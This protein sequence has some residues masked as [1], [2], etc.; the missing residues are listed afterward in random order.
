MIFKYIQNMSKNVIITL[1][2]AMKKIFNIVFVTMLFLLSLVPP[3]FASEVRY[4]YVSSTVGNGIS[5]RKGPGTSYDKLSDGLGE[6]EQVKILSEHKPDDNTTSDC[7]LWYKI[8]FNEVADGIGYA[9]AD[10]IKIIEIQTDEEFEESLEAFPESY[11][12][13]LRLLH[14][15]YPNAIFKAYDTRLDFNTVVKNE[16][17]LGKSLIWDSNSSR[18]GLKNMDSYDYVTNTF[19]NNYP[20]GGENWYAASEATIAYYVD[21]RNFLTESRVFMFEIL[22]Y[23]S[24]THT[25]GGV[26]AILAGSFMAREKVDGGDKSFAQVIMEAGKTYNISPYYL[27]S[28]ILQET[29]Y[30]RSSLVKGDY[31]GVYDQFDGYYNFFNYGAGGTDVVYNGLNYAYNKGWNSEE[32][33]IFGGTSLIGTSYINVGQ[34]TGY[35]QKWD[36]VC[37]KDDVNDCSFYSHQYMQNIEAPY[38]EANSTYKAYKEIFGDNLYNLPFI[39]TVPIYNNMPDQTILPS[40]D[41]PINYLKSL[42]VNGQSVANF[43]SLKTDYSIRLLETTKSIKVD[44]TKIESRS[45]IKGTGTIAITEDGQVIPITVTAQN[46]DELIYNITVDL[47]TIDEN[48]MTLDDTISS[49]K[50]GNFHDNYVMG[51]TNVETIINAVTDANELAEVRIYNLDNEEVTSG[52]VGTGYKVTITVLEES[53]TF[54]VV[55]YGDTNGDSEIDILDLL[56]VQKHILK[57][58]TLTGAQAQ[59]GDVSKD[60]TIDIL[61]LLRVQKHILGVSDIIQ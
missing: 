11:H 34:D 30:T 57:A 39:F 4:G 6:G 15:I 55:I 33:A 2:E 3:V 40:E 32:K 46:G 19:A 37:S 24:M 44:A 21:P 28:R 38:S 41:N 17:T 36:V 60:E 42:T 26:D 13:Y 5:V 16:A 14:T 7:S 23:S 8:E 49:I 50:S 58:S 10:L 31:D 59:A 9:C 53:K 52:S 22:S 54:E 27:A 25:E 61:D 47:I 43:N 51:L 48:D 35:F 29:G 56:R 12:D 1:G 20:G 45:S 18:D